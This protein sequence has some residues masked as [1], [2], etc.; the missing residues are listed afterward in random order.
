MKAIM[1]YWNKPSRCAYLFLAPSVILLLLFNV[2]PLAA[3]F[4]LS[5]FDVP[6]TMNTARFVGLENFTA[7]FLD[8]R[9]I[10]SLK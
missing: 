5:F 4:G 1:K 9:F 6:I 7:A 10:N 8:E 2:I 3:A